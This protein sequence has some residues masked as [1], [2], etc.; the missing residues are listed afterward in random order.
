MIKIF[1]EGTDVKRVLIRPA[2]VSNVDIFAQVQQFHIKS[3]TTVFLFVLLSRCVY[4]LLT[5]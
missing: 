1:Q 4:W 3:S 5:N 2:S